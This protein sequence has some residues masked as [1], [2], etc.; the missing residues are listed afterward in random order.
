MALDKM[1]PLERMQAI[2]N[3]EQADRLPCVPN[4]DNAAAR[5]YGCKISE[6]ASD[7][8]ALANA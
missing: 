3:G 1:T 5:V 4:I 6:F 7:P 8:Q 2:C